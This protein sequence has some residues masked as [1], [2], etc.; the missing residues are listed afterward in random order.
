MIRLS[1]LFI[2]NINNNYITNPISY[3]KLNRDKSKLILLLMQSVHFLNSI[4]FS[5]PKLNNKIMFKHI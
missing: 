4:C 5:W 1:I 2:L 3:F